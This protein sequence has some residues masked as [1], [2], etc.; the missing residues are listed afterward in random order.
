MNRLNKF[1]VAMNQVRGE[2]QPPARQPDLLS[3]RSSR[4]AP[5]A[6]FTRGFSR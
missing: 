2:S 1:L 4:Q 6:C 3:D 5:N